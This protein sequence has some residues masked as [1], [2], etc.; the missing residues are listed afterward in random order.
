MNRR[1]NVLW[2]GLALMVLGSA[3]RGEELPPEIPPAMANALEPAEGQKMLPD[4]MLR[5]YGWMAGM[6]AGLSRLGLTEAELA[7]F[8]A[9]VAAASAGEE[10]TVDPASIA[11]EISRMVQQKFDAH[12]SKLKAEQATQA[13]EFWERLKASPEVVVLPSGL[14][15]TL[16]RAGKGPRP[17]PADTIRAHYTGTLI[18]GT[19]FDSSDGGGP[20]ETTLNR[21]IQGWTEGLGLI[22]AGGAI[23]LYVPP[24]L[25]YGDA[26]SGDIPP[27]ATLIFDVELLEVIPVA[28]A[29]E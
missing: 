19:V 13:A 3:A 8:Q 22:G 18:D 25:G 5:I 27:G 10:P 9:G 23:K 16:V 6:R 7:A 26:G 29:A 15:Y 21:V 14:A 20:F 1:R 28:G 11:P 17:K 4:E 24:E 2:M 12:M